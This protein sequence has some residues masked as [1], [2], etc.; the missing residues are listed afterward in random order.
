MDVLSDLQAPLPAPRSYSLLVLARLARCGESAQRLVGAASVL[1]LPASLRLA[2]QLADI[3]GPLPALEEALGAGL[4]CEES[5]SGQGPVAKFPHPLIRAAVY[6]DLGPTRRARLHRR[7]A[8]L[9][10]DDLSA[11]QHRL[12]AAIGPDPQLTRELAALARRQ[13]AAGLWAT[14]GTLLS[15]AAR[16]VITDAE[17]QRLSVEAI[18]ALLFTGNI[19]EARAVAAELPQTADPAVRGYIA[20]HMAAVAGRVP[21]AIGLLTAAW[22]FGNRDTRPWLAARIAVGLVFFDYEK[23]YLSFPSMGE[24]AKDI[25]VSGWNVGAE[26]KVAGDSISSFLGADG[27][28]PPSDEYEFHSD[29]EETSSD[30]QSRRGDLYMAFFETGE[31]VLPPKDRTEVRKFVDAATVRFRQSMP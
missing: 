24:G 27:S 9:V 13:V 20:G 17:R 16:L 29:Y 28:G 19:D 30:T 6:Q 10:N 8:G 2:A 14:G 5:G 31:Y 7:A 11:L 3:T 1:G 18:E 25:D 22:E 26:L 12:D 4:L 15:Q 21:E 23:S